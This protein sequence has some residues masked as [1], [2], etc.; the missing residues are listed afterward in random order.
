MATLMRSEL[1]IDALEIAV[2]NRAPHKRIQ[3]PT[4]QATTRRDFRRR[5]TSACS[6]W[7]NSGRT[8]RLTLV[9]WGFLWRRRR[10]GYK[11]SKARSSEA[12]RIG[13]PQPAKPL[14]CIADL[15][16]RWRDLC[17]LGAWR[18][19]PRTSRTPLGNVVVTVTGPES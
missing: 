2:D 13:A 4:S 10:R 8:S 3:R 5:A 15:H 6:S 17:A 1:V 7:S 19:K 11:E 18:Q 14:L 16:A 12:T 9:G